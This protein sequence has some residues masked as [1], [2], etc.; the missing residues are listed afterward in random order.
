M[1]SLEQLEKVVEDPLVLDPLVLKLEAEKEKQRY[2]KVLRH[3]SDI[4]PDEV[5]MINAVT[6]FWKD[7]KVKKDKIAKEQMP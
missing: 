1:Y 4:L 6:Q 5:S 2:E 3:I 7:E